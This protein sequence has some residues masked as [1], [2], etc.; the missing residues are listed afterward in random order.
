M[1][2]DVGSPA[3]TPTNLP[4]NVVAGPGALLRHQRVGA[5]AGPL[6]RRLALG[7]LPGVVLGAVI[8]VFALP[9]PRVFRLLVAALMLPLGVWPVIRA[10]RPTP[11]EEQRPEPHPRTV[12][13][14]ALA[15]GVAGGI[16]GIGGGPLLAPVLVGRGAPVAKVAP[17]ALASD[18]ATSP[19]GASTYAVLSLA[20]RGGIAPDRLLGLACG[21]GG[22]AEAGR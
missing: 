6:V 21:L 4:C 3:V 13:G 5:L 11:P 22:V 8:R 12:T 10:L 20:H 2:A 14:P 9:G 15:V 17:R 19:F 1:H 7:T 18:F 16:Y